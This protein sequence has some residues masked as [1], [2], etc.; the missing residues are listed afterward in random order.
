M[1]YFI[2]GVCCLNSV[3]FAE[4]PSSAEKKPESRHIRIEIYDDSISDTS[5]MMSQKLIKACERFS[6]YLKKSRGLW[7]SG[8]FDS[9]TCQI[10]MP[11]GSGNQSGEKNRQNKQLWTW[12]LKIQ[13]DQE[14]KKFEILYRTS[15]GKESVQARYE[16]ETKVPIT[17]LLYK[18]EFSHLIAAYLSNSLPIRTATIG[19]RLA[20]GSTITI[21][22]RVKSSLTPE[23]GLANVYQ[24][25]HSENLWVTQL[26]GTADISFESGMKTKIRIT[27]LER[28]PVDET[29]R[30]NRKSIYYIHQFQDRDANLKKI[31]RAL[32]F[33][34]NSFF[35]KFLD[36]GR[37]AYVGARYGLPLQ[38]SKGVL[39]SA[40]MLGVFGEF[41]GGILSGLR[42]NY[43]EIPTQV[44]KTEDG[45]DEFSWS[46]FQLGYGFGF[47]FP[48]LMMNWIDISP[49]LGAT[50]FFLKHTPEPG[51]GIDGYDFRLQRAPTIGLEIGIEKRTNLFLLRLWGYGSYSVGILPIDKKYKS[52]SLRS[53]I[54]IYRELFD[55]KA[56]K[57][58]ILIFS[59]L[60]QSQYTRMTSQEELTSNPNLT[61]EVKFGSLFGG[62]GITLTW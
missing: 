57:L 14:K 54:D 36:I 62:G 59:S 33:Q 20:D 51:A 1:G 9:S 44:A 26:I 35:S 22:S 48:Y 16:L 39:A 41:R 58:A 11:D 5:N 8:P 18:Q 30:V 12:K 4:L 43:D 29:L 60:D 28:D 50:N 38:N 34:T 19:S 21:K 23:S 31:D 45:R 7:A 46:R 3:A 42:L 52:S 10:V 2:L 49:K 53:G 13:S 25:R 61:T 15:K 17:T 55:W 32:R 27:N 56:T 40:K 24:I 6:V 37:S 47:R